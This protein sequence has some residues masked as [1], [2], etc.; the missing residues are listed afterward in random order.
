MVRAANERSQVFYAGTTTWVVMCIVLVYSD[1]GILAFC[2][3]VILGIWIFGLREKFSGEETGSAY[4]V[5][6][7][8]GKAIVGGFT[9]SQFDR[10][11]RGGFGRND[12]DS[13][14]NPV[15]GSVT[16]AAYS[17]STTSFTPPSSE[18]ERLRRR[19]LSAA[20]AERRFQQTGTDS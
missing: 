18:E 16:K 14:S 5:F 6:N 9:A 10:Q 11:L 1:L 7:R 15:K 13:S 17:G 12:D 19:K 20:A 3:T 4:S 2:G 8:D